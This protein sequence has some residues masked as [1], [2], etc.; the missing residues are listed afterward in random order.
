MVI[1]VPFWVFREF[2]AMNWKQSHHDY[3]KPPTSAQR[4]YMIFRSSNSV[5]SAC[6]VQYQE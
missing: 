4:C 6:W 5:T 3:Q 2:D 1:H